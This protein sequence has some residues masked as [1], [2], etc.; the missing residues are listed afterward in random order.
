VDLF[1]DGPGHT[2]L[3]QVQARIRDLV[4]LAEHPMTAVPATD[5]SVVFHVAHSAQREVEI[6]H[7]QLLHLLAHPPGQG[8]LNPRDI[9]V[10]V[11][12]ID[13][14]APAIRSVF[15]QH[16]R[17]HARHM[18]W[19]IADQRDRGHHPLLLALEWLLRAPQQRF[20]FSELRDLL[21][22][23]A[24]ARRFG[25][26]ADDLPTLVAW[27]EGAGVR[28]GLSAPQRET[29]GLE[30]CGDANT[31]HFGLRRMLLGYATGDLEDGHAGI[32]P[33]TEVAGLAAGLAG[34]LAELLGQLHAWWVESA[35]ARPAQAWSQS[36]RN[37]LQ[38]FFAAVDDAD[39]A[40]LAALDDAL[41]DW[42]L[43]CEGAGFEE[44]V[45]LA[46][47]REAWLQ[48]V[49]EPG[50]SR[51]FKAGGVTF[52]T[53][54]PMR[55][56]PF[57]VVC[58]LGMNDGDYPRRSARSD[59]DLMALP[60]QA[61][62][63]DRSRRDDDRQLML[64]ALLSARR[65]LYVS[66]VGRSQRDNQEQP[67]SVLVSQLRDYLAAGW[68]PEVLPSRT[69]EHPLQPFSRAYFEPGRDGQAD[70]GLLTY[71]SEWRAAHE[72]TA[73]TPPAP[74]APAAA[75]P[76]GM[77]MQVAVDPLAHFLRNPV[78]AFFRHRLQVSF[79]DIGTT[80]SDDEPFAT[81][82]LDHWQLLDEVLRGARRAYATGSGSQAVDLAANIER[83]VRR[84]Q[85]AGRLP[86]AGP[87]ARVA[88]GLVRTLEPMV[89]HWQR[90]QAAHPQAHDKH[91]LQLA[92]PDRAGLVF[93]DW[94]V[95]LKSTGVTG[96]AAVWIELQASRLADKQ[97]ERPRADKLLGAWVRCLASAACGQ[98]AEGW[99][100]G[101]DAVLRVQPPDAA[102]AR[103][104]LSRLMVCFS[105]GLS[106][107]KPLPTAVRTGL[108]LIQDPGN[109]RAAY[110]GNDFGGPGEGREACLARLFPDFAALRA[111]P[112]FEPRS[113]ELYGAYGDW[114][115]THVTV[116]A[117]PDHA[118]GE[119]PDDE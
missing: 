90:L 52:C 106:G 91:P 107:D 64:D 33:Y 89:G 95:G 115:S 34:A 53:L 4:P 61:R 51:R 32:E 15:G 11:P 83:Q 111:E 98:P 86:L 92:H 73:T 48:A 103:V 12:D 113:Y 55:A 18:P 3:E 58:L 41:T 94:L 76:R 85:R 109:A 66:W 38:S 57:E 13:V 74:L 69:T 59:F 68:G 65:V 81:T 25:V 5:R 62:P 47:V 40:L 19:G 50:V 63:G 43:A 67:P 45:D 36:L 2:L 80:V 70:E 119:D 35:T 100:I 9:V 108:A 23:P 118:S 49:D 10:M 117:L 44:A 93:D 46:V 31:W 30:A 102:E 116:E 114:L 56:I 14:F 42:L 1:D 79:E 99:L 8:R 84:L 104:T 71:A 27:I 88:D 37:L 72:P 22:V 29:L 24:V 82:G 75:A 97:I 17:G 16:P 77:P 112:E 105:E 26:S 7:D 96:A 39:R 21:D 28:W 20:T 78:K 6:L 60:G 54:L 87:G 110:E 101:A